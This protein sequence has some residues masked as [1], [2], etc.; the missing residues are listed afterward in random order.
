MEAAGCLAGFRKIWLTG[1][2]GAG[3]GAGGVVVDSGAPGSN[4]TTSSLCFPSIGYT[5]KGKKSFFLSEGQ[6]VAPCEKKLLA[7][8][9]YAIV[10]RQ[11]A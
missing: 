8:K 2:A 7:L 10:G 5:P 9:P 4:Q 11:Y 3:A 1:G 6:K